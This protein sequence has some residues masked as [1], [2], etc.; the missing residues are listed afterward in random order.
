MSAVVADAR[1]MPIDRPEVEYT[2]LDASKI[3]QIERP[4]SVVERLWNVQIVRNLAV[5]VMFV[6]AWEGYTRVAGVTPLLFPSFSDTCVAIVKA[7]TDY[8]ML[9]KITF[10]MGSLLSGFAVG[11]FVAAVLVAF[12]SVWRLWADILTTATAMFNPL[13]SIA[14]LPLSMLWFGL[15]TFSLVFIL[16]HSVLWAVA[17]NAYTGFQ[18]V[19]QTQRMV[20]QN[21]GLRGVIFAAKILIPAALATVLSGM[22]IGWA[23][24]WRTMIGA[25]LVFGATAQGGGL[26]WHIFEHAELLNTPQVFAGLFI[27]I[28][29]GLAVEYLI[30]RTIE[31]RTVRRWGMQR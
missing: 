30:F 14:I 13:P 16:V 29:I 28:V 25:E 12:A 11:L 17:L 21:Y 1:P 31:T 26:G 9:S 23:F 7:F 27:I 20:G 6:A 2:P 22:K 24:A 10:T 15:G 18:G 3:G 4:L 5:L 19:S 8:R